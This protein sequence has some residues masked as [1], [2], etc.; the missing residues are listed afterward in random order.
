M[1]SINL[2]CYCNQL[3]HSARVNVSMY[4]T[5]EIISMNY[6]LIYMGHLLGLRFLTVLVVLVVSFQVTGSDSDYHFVHRALPHARTKRSVL[7]TRQ[8]KADPL[9]SCPQKNRFAFDISVHQST[10]GYFIHKR[11]ALLCSPLRY[12]PPA[13]DASS[14]R[15]R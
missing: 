3:N 9:V 12:S 7:H 11:S 1:I 2:C 15:D 13:T 4:N 14:R 5:S 8:L 6:L 10:N